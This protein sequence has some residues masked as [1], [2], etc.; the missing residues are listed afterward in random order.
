MRDCIHDGVIRGNSGNGDSPRDEEVEQERAGFDVGDV[1]VVL[2][3][4][5]MLVAP[6]QYFCLEPNENVE[7]TQTNP[8]RGR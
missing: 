4:E 6:S 2:T 1:Y 8:I 7:N 5:N 3:E